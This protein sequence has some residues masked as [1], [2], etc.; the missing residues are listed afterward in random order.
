M[1]STLSAVLEQQATTLVGRERELARL[2]ED[3]AV[4]AAVGVG[5]ARARL[6]P[7]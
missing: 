5:A 4:V 1:S 7:R 6:S 3:G 2:A